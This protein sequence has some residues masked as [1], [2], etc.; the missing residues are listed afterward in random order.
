MLIP[1]NLKD[2][3]NLDNSD[4]ISKSNLEGT[5][6]MLLNHLDSPSSKGPLIIK[7]ETKKNENFASQTHGITN[8]DDE[9]V[10]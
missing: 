7:K 10:K 3:S 5:R 8:F 9:N 6:N 2:T 4:F 1:K